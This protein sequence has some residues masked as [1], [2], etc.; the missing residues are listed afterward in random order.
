MTSIF[1]L[2]FFFRNHKAYNSVIDPTSLSS[3]LAFTMMSIE[4]DVFVAGLAAAF[5]VNQYHADDSRSTRKR[6]FTYFC[7]QSLSEKGY[8]AVIV[9]PG[10]KA[11]GYETKREKKFEGVIYTIFAARRETAM[12]VEN[13]GESGYENWALSGTNWI[14]YDKIV[15]FFGSTELSE[16]SSS[17]STSGSKEGKGHVRYLYETRPRSEFP[18]WE[19]VK[20]TDL[21]CLFPASSQLSRHLFGTSTRGNLVTPCHGDNDDD[22]SGLLESNDVYCQGFSLLSHQDQAKAS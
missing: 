22:D 4:H 11:Q 12:I 20:Y 8:N 16:Y 21:V 3:P 19:K 2:V 5:F 9:H 10:W 17:T 13:C 18:G 6:K 7:V 1:N 15:K 14:R